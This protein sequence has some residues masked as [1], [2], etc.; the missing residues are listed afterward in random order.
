MKTKN[1]HLKNAVVVSRLA[2]ERCH[3][4]LAHLHALMHLCEPADMGLDSTVADGMRSIISSM[5]QDL[6]SSALMLEQVE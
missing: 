1:L 4:K 2:L 3:Y 6:S 5:E